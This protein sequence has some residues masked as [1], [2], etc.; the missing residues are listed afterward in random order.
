MNNNTEIYKEFKFDAAHRLTNLPEGHSCGNLH[1]HTFTVIVHVEGSIEAET[2]WVM[3]YGTIKQICEP[4][5]NQLDHNY[6]NNI[7]GL[8]NP[9]SEN[10]AHW[11]W[12]RIKPQL[13]ELSML[14]IKETPTSGCRYRG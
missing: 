2:G 8:S 3:D 5:I 7:D 6:L 1:G 9:T 11:L 10:I 4:V 12:E 13:P 14:E